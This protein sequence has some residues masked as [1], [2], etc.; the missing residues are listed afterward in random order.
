[1][2]RP[3]SGSEGSVTEESA[4]ATGFPAKPSGDGKTTAAWKET[5]LEADPASGA[6]IAGFAGPLCPAPN[7]G[8]RRRPAL[9]EGFGHA[10]TAACEV[11]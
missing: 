6:V 11:T 2:W 8:L 3:A 10:P 4:R 5:A 7:P 9:G 1:M